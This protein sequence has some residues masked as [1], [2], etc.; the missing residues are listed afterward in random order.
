MEKSPARKKK[1][2]RRERKPS[3]ERNKVTR[4]PGKASLPEDHRNPPAD[5]TEESKVGAD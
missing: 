2:K 4:R 3:A 1:R 5:F